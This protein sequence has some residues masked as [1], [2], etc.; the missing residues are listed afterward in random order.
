[1][2]TNTAL[3]IAPSGDREIVMTRAFDATR[4]LVFDALTK[5]D[6]GETEDSGFT[7]IDERRN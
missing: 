6:L 5:P 2:N 4:D 7:M 1:M 3:K